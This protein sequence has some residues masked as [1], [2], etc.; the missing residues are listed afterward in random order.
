MAISLAKVTQSATG[1]VN[2]AGVTNTTTLP[3]LPPDVATASGFSVF[4]IQFP[5]PSLVCKQFD[6]NAAGAAVLTNMIVT[7]RAR[8]LALGAILSVYLARN[9]TQITSP[10]RTAALT[11]V[12]D[13]YTFDGMW[14]TS[15]TDNDMRGL[16][17]V[18]TVAS[19][20]T[21]EHEVDY[22]I[23]QC[24]YPDGDA[25][26]NS[27][28]FAPQTGVALNTLTTSAGITISGLGIASCISVAG[29]AYSINNSN[30]WL[31]SAGAI[32]NNDSVRVRHT[33]SGVT[34]Q[35]VTTTLTI[36]GISAGFTSTSTSSILTPDNFS[37]PALFGVTPSS[38]QL[39]NSI[40]VTGVTVP[41]SVSASGGSYQVEG[42]DFAAPSM[43]SAGNLVTAKVTASASY[44]T[45]ASVTVTIG[46]MARTFTVTTRAAATAPTAFTFTTVTGVA[47]STVM[48]SNTVTMAG[49]DTSVA[50]SVSLGT[51]SKNGG[52]YTAVAGTVVNGDTLTVRHTSAAV[53][54]QT[55]ITT[56]TVGT[57]TRTYTSATTVAALIPDVFTFTA[58][59]NAINTILYTS[60]NA[61]ITGITAAVPVSATNGAEFQIAAGA[62][63]TT[64]S[65]ISGQTLAV[66][67][68]SSAQPGFPK[69]TVVSVGAGSATYIVTT[70]YVTD[71][72]I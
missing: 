37:F 69:T 55:V 39:S 5:S 61:T 41:V 22:V 17:V 38:V 50:V 9:G 29:G 44:L 33:S 15:L 49:L 28:A 16:Q 68:F 67:M 51:Y 3:Y 63:V 48:T 13:V 26:P 56:L 47:V 23:A 34:G 54:N 1:W 4:D 19:V 14:G 32:Y 57:L 58:V 60:N 64:G 35:S 52:A 40:Q 2:S 66:R 25:I 12:L 42:V 20:G 27:F 72:A 11:Q 59:S 71:P 18:I 65:I 62:W 6:L 31:T 45:A 53:G 46:G 30:T 70:D 10:V 43:V 8:S 24:E 36:G 21:E 7:I